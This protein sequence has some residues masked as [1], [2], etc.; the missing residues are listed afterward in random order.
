MGRRRH[1]PLL[2][3]GVWSAGNAGVV[4]EEE[5]LSGNMLYATLTKERIETFFH[6]REGE[7][8]ILS[9]S[10]ILRENLEILNAFSADKEQ[11]E[12]MYKAFG[13]FLAEALS[14]L[15]ILHCC[16]R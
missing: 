11:Q 7:V 12:E 8:R 6:S 16:C 10:R 4:A 5:I 14:S 3:F 1:V 9:S 15:A 13:T 2:L